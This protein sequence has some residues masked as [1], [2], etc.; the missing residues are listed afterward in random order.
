[1]TV[2]TLALLLMKAAVTIVSGAACALLL[3]LWDFCTWPGMIFGWYQPWLASVANKIYAPALW[4]EIKTK[5][6]GDARRHKMVHHAEHL[7]FYKVLGGCVFCFGVWV[8][9]C[10]YAAVSAATG[11]SWWYAPVHVVVSHFLLRILIKTE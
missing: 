3:Y 10:T 9:I 5:Y 11:I 1:M 2:T 4:R 7:A 6:T 8:A